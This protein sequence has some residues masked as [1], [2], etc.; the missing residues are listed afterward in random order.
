[1]HVIATYIYEQ[2]MT[3]KTSFNCFQL[4]RWNV[5][6]LAHLEQVTSIEANI[7]ALARLLW[8][9]PTLSHF[10]IAT[11]W[12]HHSI[13]KVS[14]LVTS[15]AKLYGFV[16]ACTLQ[17]LPKEIEVRERWCRSKKQTTRHFVVAIQWRIRPRVLGHTR[18][19]LIL[20]KSFVMLDF[21]RSVQRLPDLIWSR[22]S[23]EF[24]WYHRNRCHLRK[25]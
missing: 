12:N 4:R 19:R 17:E 8:I 25:C 24:V 21:E 22:N 5:I 16:G 13:E 23:T 14:F 7:T 9:A 3:I 10:E 2:Y 11:T 1:M 20:F 15:R 18:E 6:T